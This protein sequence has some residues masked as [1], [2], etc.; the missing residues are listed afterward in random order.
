[1]HHPAYG[2]RPRGVLSPNS[3]SDAELALTGDVQ[4]CKHAADESPRQLASIW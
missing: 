3:S 1:M 2:L 4:R